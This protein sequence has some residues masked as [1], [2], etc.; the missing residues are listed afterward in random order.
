MTIQIHAYRYE[1]HQTASAS[2]EIDFETLTPVLMMSSIGL[3]LS[4]LIVALVAS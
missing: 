1:R 2:P 3:T 4:L